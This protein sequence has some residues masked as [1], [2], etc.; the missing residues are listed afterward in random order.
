[1]MELDQKSD[2]I[3]PVLSR[4]ARGGW[5]AVSPPGAQFA[6]GVTAPTPGDAENLF[7]FRYKKWKEYFLRPAL[8]VPKSG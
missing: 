2:R 3:K 8:D 1:M 4:R 7:R 6:I 5:L